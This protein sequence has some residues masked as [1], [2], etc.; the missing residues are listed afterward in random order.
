MKLGRSKGL[1]LG[2]SSIKDHQRLGLL[3]VNVQPFADD[4]FTIVV[5][6]HQRL[7]GLIVKALPL[8]GGESQ[9]G[10]LAQIGDEHGAR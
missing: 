7:A 6:Q 2:P 1:L 10:K 4:F 3:M 5:A 8:G 9:R